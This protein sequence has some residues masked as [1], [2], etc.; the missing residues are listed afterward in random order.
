MITAIIT[1]LIYLCLLVLVVYLVIWV[2][3]QIGISLPPQIMNIIWV[4]I[5]LVAILVIVQSV[6]PATG[7]RLGKWLG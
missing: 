4:I 3:Q 2:L 7:V 1:A 6:L 5:A